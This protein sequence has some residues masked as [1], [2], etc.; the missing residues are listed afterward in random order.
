MLLKM[1]IIFFLLRFFFGSGCCVIAIPTSVGIV[2]C[3]Y[4]D[5]YLLCDPDPMRHE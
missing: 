4:A 5:G 2:P 3:T 1:T